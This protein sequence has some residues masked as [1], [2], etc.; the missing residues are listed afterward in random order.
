[1][2]KKLIMICASVLVVL[3]ALFAFTA[4]NTER[5]QIG[6]ELVQNGDF[7]QFD[8]SA[9]VFKGWLTSSN[10]NYRR[11]QKSSSVDGEADFE[12]SMSSKSTSNS[13]KIYQYVYQRIQVDVNCVYKVSVDIRLN[14]DIAHDYGAY[15]TFLENTSFKRYHREKTVVDGSDTAQY[16]TITAYVRPR[17]TD[18]LTLAL[19]MGDEENGAVGT[20]LFDNVSMQRVEK[21]AVPDGYKINNIRKVKTVLSN[22]TVSGIIFTVLCTVGS[23][24]LL[25][26]AYIIIKRIYANKNAFADFGRVD[27]RYSNKN[28]GKP[29]WYQNTAFIACMI[30]L[31]AVAV[32]LVLML[33]TFGN[34]GDM[35]A[36]VSLAKKL[37][38]RNGV[39]DYFTSNPAATLSPGVAYILAILGAAGNNLPAGSVSILLRLI[40][41]LADIAVVMLIYFYGSKKVGN[42]FATVYAALYALLPFTFVLSGMN[43][44]FESVL[45]A[46]LLVSTLLMLRK[47]YLATYGVMTLAVVL[48][49]RAFAIAPIIIAYFVY[50][51][52]KD[53]DDIK[54]F[55]SKRAQMVFG[56]PAAFVLGYLLTLPAAIDLVKAGDAFANYKLIVNEMTNYSYFV[57]NAFNLYGM[58]AMNDKYVTSSVSILN[59]VFVLVLEAYVISLYFKNRNRNELILLI[60]FTLT[61]VAVFTVKVDYTYL[62]LGFV[63]ALIY[64]MISGDVRMYGVL[65]GYGVFGILGVAQLFSQSGF[66]TSNSASSAL[67]SFETTDPFYIIFCV[68]TVLLTGYYVYVTYS[69]TNNTKIVDITAMPEPFGKTVAKAFKNLKTRFKKSAE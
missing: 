20:V 21:S 55:T 50:C 30:A 52:I 68:L 33:T 9:K 60:S 39:S 37:G 23:A 18:Y 12:L 35:A 32:R 54:K 67:T 61:V 44:S 53:N 8:E 47:Q 31:G 42:R 56:L 13:D 25:L 49:I 22:T 69:I 10:A 1:M 51:Y 15:F 64:T 28:V 5:T 4:C 40:N 34:G 6:D 46:L 63:F 62:F 2:K 41:V 45:V 19:C 43:G 3:L 17:N 24:A 48:D 26:A 65:S 16:I 66:I 27:D 29:K 11:S 38:L 14:A 59:L 36:Q 7:S 58:V 57:H